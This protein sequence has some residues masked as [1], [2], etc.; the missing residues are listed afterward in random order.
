[1]RIAHVPTTLK[2]VYVSCETIHVTFTVLKVF[3]HFRRINGSCVTFPGEQGKSHQ[4][5]QDIPGRHQEVTLKFRR[6]C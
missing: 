1:M 5:I 6:E 3:G 4:S 2:P